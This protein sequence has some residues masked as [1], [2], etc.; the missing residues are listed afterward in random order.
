MLKV[1]IELTFF[2]CFILIRFVNLI[3]ER[4]QS[5]IFASPVHSLADEVG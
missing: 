4:F 2:H 5:R 3:T 1:L